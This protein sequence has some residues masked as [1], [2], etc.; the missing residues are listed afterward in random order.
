MTIV[1]CPTVGPTAPTLTRW[2]TT[3][4]SSRQRAVSRVTLC[5]AGLADGLQRMSGHLPP[6]AGDTQSIRVWLF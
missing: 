2:G 6:Q 5:R 4:A 3:L 1:T